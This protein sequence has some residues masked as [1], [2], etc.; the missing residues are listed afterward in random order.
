MSLNLFHYLHS[1]RPRASHSIFS[2]IFLSWNTKKV[3]KDFPKT[4]NTCLVSS[5]ASLTS[6]G[7]GGSLELVSH[8]S[9][10]SVMIKMRY[11]VDVLHR[12][13]SQ[14]IFSY[15]LVKTESGII[16]RSVQIGFRRWTLVVAVLMLILFWLSQ[17]WTVTLGIQE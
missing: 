12:L 1:S 16:F 9:S 4:L 17:T 14:P 5:R 15:W 6:W 2:F 7:G 13:A 11:E 8:P 3:Q 10:D